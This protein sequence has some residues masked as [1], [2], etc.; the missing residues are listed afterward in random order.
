[1]FRDERPL[2]TLGQFSLDKMPA[3]WEQI[4]NKVYRGDRISDE[5]AVWLY[6]APDAHSGSEPAT[7]PN[8]VVRIRYPSVEI[9]RSAAML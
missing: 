2:H 5:E 4:E 3:M 8:T 1:M 7:T 9:T 6:R